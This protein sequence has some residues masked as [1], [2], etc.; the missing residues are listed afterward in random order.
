LSP[1]SPSA[2]AVEKTITLAVQHMTCAAGP[3]TVEA[4][5]QAVPGVNN[6]VVSFDDKTAVVTFDDSKGGGGCAREGDDERGLSFRAEELS[7]TG[8]KPYDETVEYIYSRSHS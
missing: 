4:S 3:R 8:R 5:L 1:F 7:G 6:V 2:F